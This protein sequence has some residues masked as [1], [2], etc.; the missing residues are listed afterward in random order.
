MTVVQTTGRQIPPLRSTHSLMFF[1]FLLELL[2]GEALS[3]CP[4]P[5]KKMFPILVAT[6]TRGL[7]LP[8]LPRRPLVSPVW[9]VWP[10]SASPREGNVPSVT[11]SDEFFRV[12]Y[13]LLYLTYLNEVQKAVHL[14]CQNPQSALVI[15]TSILLYTIDVQ[16]T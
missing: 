16:Q 9:L 2:Q 14:D 3:L 4:A 6:V 7:W 12:S 5:P 13:S 15:A 1:S 8:L 10:R 11:R